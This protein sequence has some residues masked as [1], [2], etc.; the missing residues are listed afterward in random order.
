MLKFI[1]GVVLGAAVT[2]ATLTPLYPVYAQGANTPLKPALERPALKT[3]TT[4]GNLKNVMTAPRAAANMENVREKMAS[5]AAALKEK[6]QKFKDKVKASRVE[7]L[8]ENMNTINTRRTTEMQ[9]VLTKISLMLE[10]I[11]S[12]TEEAGSAGKDVAAVNTAI[13]NLEKEWKE[14]DA[15]VKAQLEKDY[16]IEVTSETTVKEDASIVRSSLKNDLQSVHTQVVQAKQALANAI[17]TALSSI[18]GGNTNGSQ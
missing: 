14:A 2:V 16:T 8:N 10:R 9:Q 18:K 12:K 3:A 11:K 7:N 17:S 5:R 6:L 1:P 13:A 15:A 4:P